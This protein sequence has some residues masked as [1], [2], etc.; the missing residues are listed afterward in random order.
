MCIRDRINSL[1][2]QPN[3][4]IR[5]IATQA[6]TKGRVFWKL[7]IFEQNPEKVKQDKIFEN[8]G[9]FRATPS[10]LCH[11]IFS[12]RRQI[13]SSILALYKRSCNQVP[14][15][16]YSIFNRSSIFSWNLPYGV[17]CPYKSGVRPRKSFLCILL[18]HAGSAK[19]F[20]T[21]NVLIYTIHICKRCKDKMANSCLLYTSP[22][23]RD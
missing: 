12:S 3:K 8:V 2:S 11:T 5:G 21:N 7:A 15:R 20:C 10:G 9:Y 19:T 22:S 1:A 23:P 6:V 16:C 17:I 18:S 14:C 4:P 13:I